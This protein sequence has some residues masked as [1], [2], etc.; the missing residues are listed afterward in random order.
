MRNPWLDI[1]EADYV[2]HM[3]SP[4]VDQRRVLNALFREVLQNHHPKAVLV[5]GC[6][7]GNGFEHVDP[8][9][10]ERVAALE[11]NATFVRR[12]AEQFSKS[13][14]ELDVRCA[15]VA[16]ASLEPD[17]FD[18][19]HAAL[20]FEYVDWTEILPRLVASLRSGGAL[21]VVLQ[22]PSSA[23]PAVT[24]TGFTSLLA[25]HSIFRFVDPDVLVEQAQQLGMTLITRRTVPLAAAKA[26][27][28]LCFR[29]RRHGQFP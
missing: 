27:E 10:T 6:S 21:S 3:S 1:S 20:I 19:I 15:D 13:G 26:F 24:P 28:A 18:L 16:S 29:G 25:L 5:L 11:I 8:D 4:A 7:T 22:R 14:F 23:A 2:G 12:V 17:A 9:V